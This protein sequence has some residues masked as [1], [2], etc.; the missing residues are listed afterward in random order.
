MTALAVVGMAAFAV[1]ALAVVAMSIWAGMPALAV[2]TGGRL[3]DGDVAGIREQE[4]ASALQ[5][6][7]AA[8]AGAAE[9]EAALRKELALSR[10]E[11]AAHL[12]ETERLQAEVDRL[13]SCV[14]AALD[15]GT[16]KGRQMLY[17]E[18][19]RPP[20]PRAND[21]NA[22]KYEAARS[23]M[24]WR[25]S[26]EWEGLSHA[27]LTHFDEDVRPDLRDAAPGE[28]FVYQA[29]RFVDA[30]LVE[31]GPVHVEHAR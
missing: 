2:L 13:N 10:V 11:A 25:N 31:S 4:A 19:L 28:V 5:G 17:L 6:A 1:V 8:K 16:Y 26:D 18:G 30:R 20:F 12:E 23:E 22:R 3:S 21:R 7:A 15:A 24:T 9:V 29:G 14:A 27:V